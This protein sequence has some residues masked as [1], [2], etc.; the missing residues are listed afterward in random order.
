MSEITIE[1]EGM[2]ISFEEEKKPASRP[3]ATIKWEKLAYYVFLALGF[4]L[5]FWAWPFGGGASLGISKSLLFFTLILAAIVFYLIHILQ[6]GAVKYSKS[7][8]FLSLLGL[9]AV[10]LVSSFFAKPMAVSLFG[11]GGEVGTFFFL[12]FSVI[13][14]FLITSIF[15]SEKRILNFFSAIILSSIVVFILQFAHSVLSLNFGALSSSRI[16][17]FLG[18]W[19]ELAIF[20][21]LVALVAII[22]L[23]FF[24]AKKNIRIFLYSV[25]GM[26]LLSMALINFTAA[27]IVFGSLL[28]VL[29]VYLFSSQGDTRNFA[30]LPLLIILVAMFF[31]LAQP[32]VGDLINSAGLSSVDVRPSWSATYDVVKSAWE[33]G[34]LAFI[35]GSGPNTFVYDWIKFKPAEINQTIFWNTR[36]ASGIGLIPTFAATGGVLGVLAWLSFLLFILYYGFKSVGYSENSVTKSLLLVSFLGSVYLWTFN[37]IYS[38]SNFLFVLSF[39]VTGTFF[40]MLVK[41]GI[42]NLK[43]FSFANKTSV[44]FVSSLLIVLLLIGSVATFYLFFQKY[45]AALSYNRGIAAVNVDGNLDNGENLILKAT[46]FDDQDRFERSLSQIGLLQLSRLLSQNLPQEEMKIQFQNM[47]AFT[48]QH[49]QQATN[50][51]PVDPLNWNTLGSVY[52]NIIPFQIEGTRDVALSS[53]SSASEVAPTDPTP[54][55]YSAQVEAQYG[56]NEEAKSF[57]NSALKIKGDYT[58]ALFLLSQIAAQEGDLQGAIRQTEQARLTAPNDI[59]ILFQLG[60]LY[61]QAG[62]YENSKAI[63]ERTITLS[64]DYSNARYFLGL[65]Y[66][67]LGQTQNAIGQFERIEALN[68]DNAEVPKILSNLKNGKKALTNISPPGAA[69]ENRTAPPINED[70]G[71]S[72]DDLNISN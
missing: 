47:L 72:Q 1:D 31:V 43:V 45:W 58:D 56:N 44:G 21:G 70:T 9:L 69:P 22:F 41:S 30:R 12:L 17:S 20:F 59:G 4:L 52:Q 28:L 26:S 63:L 7:F 34:P 61:Y 48:I 27:W 53:Y 38:T 51:N 67:N 39:F 37:I 62:D 68:P 40:A 35:F 71:T 15:S 57:L 11:S 29:L 33:Q 54:L 13:S 36:F 25:L 32:F 14:F 2:E 55:F 3:R 6:E 24:D 66:D 8:I 23:E 50:I 60:L 65:A 64:P 18:A 46:Q 19:S 10:Y 5:P 49:A 16:D 42:I